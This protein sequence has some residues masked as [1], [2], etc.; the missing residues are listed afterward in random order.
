M[1]LEDLTALGVSEEQAQKIL[2]VC[3]KEINKAVSMR[4][5]FKAENEALKSQLAER[6]RDMEALKKSVGDTETTGR[7]LAELEEK[8]AADTKKYKEQIAARD[9]NDAVRAAIE[10]KRIQFSSKAAERAFLADLREKKLQVDGGNLLG[11]EEFLEA[12][13]NADPS[14]FLDGEQPPQ[15]TRGTGGKSAPPMTRAAFLSLPYER[16]YQFKTEN[17]ELFSAMMKG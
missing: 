5:G 16:Q 9:Y 11:F 6:D 12:Q 7:K 17:P 14:A 13:K 1:K 15:Y 3:E 4:D 10:G 2:S 8:Y